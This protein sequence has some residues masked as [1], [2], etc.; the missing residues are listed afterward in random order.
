MPEFLVGDF[1]S[2]VV[3]PVTPV[4]VVSLPSISPLPLA[5]SDPMPTLIPEDSVSQ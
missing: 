4:V 2:A 3:L 1:R 5:S